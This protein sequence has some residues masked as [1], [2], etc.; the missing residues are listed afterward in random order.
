MKPLFCI[1]I[2]EDKNNFVTNGD[3]FV[4]QKTEEY[5]VE[6]VLNSAKPG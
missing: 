1:D 5:L 3:E 2:T 4:V 6:D